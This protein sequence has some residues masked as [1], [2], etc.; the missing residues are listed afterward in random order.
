MSS[1]VDP[2]I[3]DPIGLMVS[4]VAAVEGGLGAG[5]IREVVSGVAGGRAKS[6]QLAGALRARPAVLLDGGSPAPRGVADLL[7]ALRRAGATSIS[8]PRCKSCA[9]DLR[10]YQRRGEDWYCAVCGPRPEPCAGCGSWRRV[11]TRDC[12]GKP[13]CRRCPDVDGAD[14]IAVICAL[15]IAIQPDADTEVIADAVR[16]VAP[17]PSHQRRLAGALEDNPALLTGSGH[18]APVPAVLRLIEALNDHGVIGVVRPCC[19]RCHRAVRIYKPL[20]GERVCRNC[21]AKARVEPCSR[22]GAVREPATRDEHRRPICPSCLVADP[23][24]LETCVN[25]G[26]RRP[27]NTRTLHGPI[28][29]TCPPLPTMVCSICTESAPCGISRL[30]GKPWC[31]ACQ[32]RSASCSGCGQVKAV[33]SGSL[34]EPRCEDC[35]EAALR[36]G[37]PTCGE[38]PRPGGCPHCRLERRLRELMGGPDGCVHPA[39]VTLHEALA[40]TK[41]PTTALR[42]LTRRTVSTFLAD[43]AAGRR[44]LNHQALDGLPQ[45]PT[46]EH[47]RSVLVSTGALPARDEH[48]ARLERVIDELVD[49]R[50]DPAEGQ[51]LHR[52]AIWHLLHRLRRRTGGQPI[53]HEQLT[54]VRQQLHAAIALLDWLSG[55]HLTLAT[56]GQGDLER[57]LSRPEGVNHHHPGSFVRWATKQQLTTLVFPATRWQGPATTPDDQAR[58]EVARR[59]LHDDTLNIRDRVAGLLVLLY[60]QKTTT[61]AR[62]TIDRLD[63]ADAAVRLRLGPVP[64]VLPDPLAQL[65][66]NLTTDQHGHATT[67]ADGPSPW[68]FPGGQPGRPISAGH[69]RQRL[70]MIGVHPRQARNS[71][72]SQLAAELPA[73]ILARLLGIDISVAVAWQRISGGDWMTYAADV[74]RRPL[75]ND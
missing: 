14:P 55:E 58:W 63:T 18:L 6:R 72:L 33:R 69:L 3:A 60:A 57:W 11:A 13:R 34:D 71:A 40:T 35:T 73:A 21:L 52:Y 56:A 12:S 30:T 25:C 32:G 45:S 17:R 47:L 23:A 67:A 54:A 16:A 15:V 38:R 59:L 29:A 28:C 41:P 48:M 19:P 8:S 49:T 53:T 50:A 10:T 70:T 75:A 44:A 66:T 64:I 68:L 36:P 24:N 26:R 9:K 22:C 43:V 4:L 37:C 20:D 46:L 42:W 27:V 65:V 39:L 5:Q 31:F 51:L 1:G 2:A 61:I 7:I 62:L 74:S